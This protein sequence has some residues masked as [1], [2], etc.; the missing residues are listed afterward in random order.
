[1]KVVNKLGV[2]LIVGA[3]RIVAA[4]ASDAEQAYLE[5]CRKA[6]GV[7]VPV[8]VVTPTVGPEFNGGSVQL[9]FVVD[10]NG[11]PAGFSI[12]SASDDVLARLVVD[13]VRQWRFLPATA[14]G[15]PV[16]TKVALPVNIVDPIATLDRFAAAK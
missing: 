8:A 16:A 3:L 2:L 6:P 9:E 5:S 14:D 4:P 13:A 12:T 11:R 15:K 1:M 7:P 10:V